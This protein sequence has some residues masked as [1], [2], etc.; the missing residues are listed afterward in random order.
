MSMSS[1]EKIEKGLSNNTNNEFDAEDQL[2]IEEIQG[3]L[4]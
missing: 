2:F 4:Q 3:I 1:W